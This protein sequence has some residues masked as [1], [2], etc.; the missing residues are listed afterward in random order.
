M[1]RKNNI[2]AQCIRGTTSY[3]MLMIHPPLRAFGKPLEIFL[4]KG[5]LKKKKGRKGEV[6]E[7]AEEK[8]EKWISTKYFYICLILF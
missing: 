3:L 7:T 2:P 5:K 4:N 1:R 8:K 6:E